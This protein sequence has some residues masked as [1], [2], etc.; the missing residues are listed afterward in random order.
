MELENRGIS[1]GLAPYALPDDVF[2]AVIDLA[3]KSD[4]LIFGALHGTQEVPR[5]ILSLLNEL[6]TAGYRG[7]ALEIPRDERYGIE[8]W[9][10]GQDSTPPDFFAQPF[11][12]GRGNRETLALIRYAAQND[13]SLL[14]FDQGPDQPARR[15]S[16]RDGWMAENLTRQ[17]QTLCPT[18]KIVAICGSMHSR[19][20]LPFLQDAL[21]SC[22]PSFAYQL[23]CVYP[24]KI[25]SAIKIGFQSGTYFDMGPR[26]LHS[27]GLEWLRPLKKPIIRIAQ[28]HS[29]ELFL[30]RATAA[31]FLAP[32]HEWTTPLTTKFFL[33]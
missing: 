9:A 3:F 22:W 33:P 16:D 10:K 14:C 19:L 1:Q 8:R 27:F 31:T 2:Q 13:W 5:I 18:V 32:P 6:T 17:W 24:D 11:A 12:D 23:C 25:V 26:R 7:L 21:T 28:D 15:W 20:T 29:C 30:P 4:M